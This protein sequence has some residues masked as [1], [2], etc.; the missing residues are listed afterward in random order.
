MKESN[1]KTATK[2]KSKTAVK[3]KTKELHVSFL[4]DRTGSMSSCLQATISGFNEYTNTL[5][6]DKKNKYL[7]TLT[8]FDS[9]SIDTIQNK[10][11][12]AKVIKLDAKNY[13]PRDCTNLYDAIGKTITE[14]GKEKD[15][16]FVIQTDGQENASKEFTR[17]KISELIKQKE[18]DGWTFVY[19]GANQDA[20]SV[21][22]S[23]GING[24]NTFTY[25]NSVKGNEI[26]YGAMAHSTVM[27]ADAVNNGDNS[28]KRSFFAKADTK[29][30]KK[31]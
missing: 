20:W 19:L 4:L 17:E 30:N 31:Q 24:A 22:Q 2:K 9:K 8:Q 14:L 28:L 26:L 11:T 15:V 23:F 29:K 25:D 6:K 27:Y 1:M 16:L 10:V 3:K 18:S 21:G 5:K 7:F 13:R 12:I